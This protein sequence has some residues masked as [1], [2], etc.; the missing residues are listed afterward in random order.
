MVAVG[1]DINRNSS[2]GRTNGNG[3]TNLNSYVGSNDANGN[4]LKGSGFAPRVDINATHDARCGKVN[5]D[6]GTGNTGGRAPVPGEFLERRQRCRGA[7]CAGS[8]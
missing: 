1:D 7:R 5:R 2:V 6:T 3:K 4:S 8:G